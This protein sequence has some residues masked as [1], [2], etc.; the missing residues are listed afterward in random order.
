MVL[1][2]SINGQQGRFIFDNAVM[3]SNVDVNVWGL[4]PVAYTQR[5]YEGKLG[6]GLIFGLNRVYFGDIE[7]KAKSLI[8]NR[9]DTIT[10]LKEYEGYDG[11][12]GMSI[13]NGYW[14]ELSFSEQKI[15][16]HKEKPNGYNNYSPARLLNINSS[17]DIPITID[18][19]IVFMTIDTG[20]SRA[21]F[22]PEEMGI[23]KNNSNYM[24]ISS[25]E[26]VEQYHLVKTN[27]IK[28][29]DETYNDKYIMT[30]SYSAKRYNYVSH[31]DVGL[32][33]L[34]FLKNYDLLFDYREIRKGETTGIFY[35]SIIPSAERDYGFFSFLDEVPIPGVLNFWISDDGLVISSILTDGIAYTKYGLRPGDVITKINNRP[36]LDFTKEEIVNPNFY[37]MIS[38]FSIMKN[39]SEIRIMF[40]L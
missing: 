2:A 32:I 17:M 7:V 35:K 16:L 39:G 38:D 10:R 11:L 14:C 4:F 30:N 3:I 33:G 12:L 9:S 20:L 13:F 18:N 31:N 36:I 6:W 5:M 28:I 40:T 15:I 37:T 21:I 24:E 34:E 27:E 8:M 23:E 29:L 1:E 22:F 19:K 25:N 26:E